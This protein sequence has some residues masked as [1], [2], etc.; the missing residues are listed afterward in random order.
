MRES[1]RRSIQ[2]WV[3][4]TADEAMRPDTI[5]TIDE[6][7]PLTPLTN[8]GRHLHTPT[9]SLSPVRGNVMFVSGS[10]GSAPT[11]ISFTAPQTGAISRNQSNFDVSIALTDVQMEKLAAA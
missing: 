3:D 11:S 6:N 5:A 7:L 1:H 9:G 4:R 2:R 10:D 8:L